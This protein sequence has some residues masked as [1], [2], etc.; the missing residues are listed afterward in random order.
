MP[1]L[2]GIAVGLDVEDA[3]QVV[4]SS[5]ADGPGATMWHAWQAGPGAPEWTL[6]QPF[7]EPGPGGPG[8]PTMYQLAA[9]GQLGVL[10]VSSG[11]QAVWHRRQTGSEPDKWSDWES[12]GQPDGDPVQGAVA[13]ATLEDG[14][15]R[16]AQ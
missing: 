9:T 13:T 10:V 4:A 7:G 6:W 14:Q 8:A 15:H 2:T 5:H 11:D 3:L 16:H 12:L 1:K